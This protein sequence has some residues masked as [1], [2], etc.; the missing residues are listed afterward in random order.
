MTSKQAACLNCR[1]SKIKCKRGS[2]SWVCEKC[3]HAGTECIIPTFHVGRQ[4]GVKNKRTG[5]ERAIFQIEEAIKKSRSA[6]LSNEGTLEQLQHL[7]DNARREIP[8]TEDTASSGSI[9]LT[10]ERYGAPQSSDDQLALD[11]AENPLQLLARASDLRLTSPQSAE[12]SA[13]TPSSRYYGSERDERSDIHRFFLPMKA[14]FDSGP[15]LDPIDI[16]LVTMEE[17]K[18]LL[19]F[20]HEKLAHTRWGLDPLVHTPSFVRRRSSFLFTS[21]LTASALFLPSTAALAKRL[22]FHRK[23]LAQQVVTKRF[24]SVEIV[25]AF[26]VNIPWM[27]PGTHSAD[28]D[29]GLYISVALSIALDLSLDKIVTPSWS[30][31]QDL[32]K[33]IPKSNCID[34]R[35]ALAMD[36]FEDVDARS[37]WGQ[38]LL[39]RRERVWISLFVLER[40][41]CLARG[42]SY[43]VPI[44][45]LIKHSDRWHS[46]GVSDSH[47]GSLISMAVLRR[48]LDDLFSA[49]RSKCDSYRVID[50]GSKVAG[51]IKATIEN[52]YDRWLA[53]WTVAI[54]EGEQKTLPP[55]VEILVTHTRL[56]TYS[57]VINHPTAPLEVK[58][59]F[60]ASALS[61]A[62]NVM[63]AAI[64]G[65]ARLKSMPNNTAIMIC[66]A[67]CVS[68][69]LSTSSPGGSH[70]L[71]PSV[72][73][74]IEETAAVLE[75]IGNTPPHRNGTSVLYGKYLRELV[76]QAPLL[77]NPPLPAPTPVAPQPVAAETS[78]LDTPINSIH[79]FPQPQYPL[80]NP[81]GEPLQFSA[82]SG[83]EVIET[84]MNAGDFDA[85]LLDFPV[86]D[87][88]AF[89]WMDWMNPPEFGF[90]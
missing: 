43:S 57:G 22:L 37:E 32:L 1:K 46:D 10:T 28:D 60:R 20:F 90:Q 70:N 74:L 68:L 26:L 76:K 49:V 6:S 41:V 54:G 61:S 16:G 66:F 12:I 86:E 34:A 72:R 62:L 35:K 67:A 31:D 42:R 85:A 83:N 5:L 19:A 89:T 8:E 3:Q 65:E 18:A 38:R 53:T 88:N 50:V 39:R 58:R 29:T 52:F 13:S 9:A 21:L 23:F 15:E 59:L 73:N 87:A 56:S 84:V 33:R 17:A 27:H 71:A 48:D 77:L 69:N 44:T 80:P 82:M 63:R 45:P 78:V 47:D 4:K 25:L 40:G 75:R 7:L 2:G 55:Y 81:W 11:D 51:E 30:F 24:R 79:P 64:Q 14:S 36:G